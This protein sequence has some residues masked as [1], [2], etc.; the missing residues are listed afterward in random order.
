MACLLV[1]TK[2]LLLSQ[3]FNLTFD[4]SSLDGE[5]R[6]WIPLY[7]SALAECPVRRG[8]QLI[9]H[10]EIISTKEQL[11]ITFSVKIGAGSSGNF[12]VGEFSNFLFLETGVSFTI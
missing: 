5:T 8:D 4:T 1:I 3:Q 7:K 11:T 6:S 2:L 9:S 10:Q 12:S